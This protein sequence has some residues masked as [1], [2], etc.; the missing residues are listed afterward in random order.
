VDSPFKEWSS[1]KNSKKFKKALQSSRAVKTPLEIEIIKETCRISSLGHIEIMK[2]CQVNLKESHLESLF[3]HFTSWRGCRQQAYVPIVGTGMNAEILHYNANNAVIKN[4]DL[5][6]I[7]AGCEYLGYA[8]D[9]TRT[10]PSNG[11][12]SDEQK[13][14][15]NV[16][17]NAQKQIVAAVRPGLEF[18][19]LSLLATKLLLE[20]LIAEKFITATLEQALKEDLLSLFMPHGL[21]HLMGL[22]V[23]DVSIYPQTPLLPG[24]IITIEPGIYFN[25]FLIDKFLSNPEKKIYLN[26]PLIESY[27]NFGGIR[28]EDDV[29][30]TD[31][32]F[33]CLTHLALKEI[34]DIEKVMSTRPR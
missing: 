3:L 13:K 6:V 33:Y 16:V 8:S 15:Y 17:L 11:V 27:R 5:V 20:G 23:H 25:N 30:V 24:M 21:G 10:F 1:Q 18:P 32:G 2:R 26:A 9:I 14:V 28:I 29:L 19:E 12:F 34:V 4:G 7:D 22:D 31:D